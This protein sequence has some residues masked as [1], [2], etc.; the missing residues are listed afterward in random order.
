MQSWRWLGTGACALLLVVGCGDGGGDGPPDDGGADAGDVDVCSEAFEFAEG[1]PDGHADP[2]GVSAG[3]ARAGR[4]SASDLPPDPSGQGLVEEGDFVLANEH[5][6][7][8]IEDVGVSD[9]W[10]VWGGKPVGLGKMEGGAIVE[11]VN[12]YEMMLSIG[13]YTLDA[14][15]VTVLDDGSDGGPARVRAVGTLRI[16]ESLGDLIGLAAP[17]SNALFEGMQVALDYELAP[18]ARAME[19]TYQIVND[20]DVDLDTYS[21][22]LFF[23]ESRLPLY[24]PGPG[25]AYA[26]G[27]TPLLAY[28]A[29]GQSG[30]AW[31]VPADAPDPGET[32][33]MIRQSGATV[34]RFPQFTMEA[35]RVHAQPIGRLHVGGPGLDG[36]LQ[37]VAAD[38]D[39]SQREITGTIRNDD[40]TPAEGVS[41]HVTYEE[42]GE[43]QYLTK[44]TT[45]AD[46]TYAVH[47]PSDLEVEIATWRRGDVP[48]GPFT[49]AASDTGPVDIDLDPVGEIR[50]AAEDEPSLNP[51]PVRVQ[52]IPEGPEAEYAAAPEEYGEPELPPGRMHVA[53]PVDGEAVLRVPPG[54]HRVVVSRGFEYTLFDE[55]I[56][57]GAGESEPVPVTLER[58]V[59]TTGYMCA[60]FHIHTADSPDAGDPKDF[61]IRTAIG[62]G[63]E[64]P[65]LSDHRWVGDFEETIAQMDPAVADWAYGVS[66]LELTT[67]VWG[68]MGVVPL[69]TQPD[70][71]NNGYIDFVG[72]DPPDVFAEVRSR[73]SGTAAGIEPAIIIN[74]GRAFGGLPAGEYFTAVE[75]SPTTGTIGR[76]EWWDESFRLIEVFNDAA[77]DEMMDTGMPTSTLRDWFSMLSHFVDRPFFAVGSSDSHDVLKKSSPVGYPRTCLN[78][79]MTDD[80]ADLRDMDGS[81]MIRDIAWGGDMNVYGGIFVTAS[82]EGGTVPMGG[83]VEGSSTTVNVRVEAPCW[84]AVDRL[85]WWVNGEPPSVMAGTMEDLSTEWE[86]QCPSPDGVFSITRDVDIDVSDTTGRSWVVFHAAGDTTMDPMHRGR[87]PF[88]V[89]NPIFFMP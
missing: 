5:V 34:F 14:E 84:I 85:E 17:F 11:P 69:A 10:D 79:D 4:L 8:A 1:E 21:L 3:E 60:D 27:R 57:V 71:P 65:V 53:F 2:L 16:I 45:G 61:K 38:R 67:F 12:F 88:G 42:E 59:D 26:E 25:Y 44:A 58:V 37:A 40:G 32:S 78:F 52:V 35:C 51:L 41:V 89:T 66:S 19:V 24:A 54:D 77:F 48:A 74:H 6:A 82:A 15:S 72:M 73:D 55:V 62:D 83:T 28:A 13:Q 7:V 63:V 39:E 75:Y 47:V 80:P 23:Q 86:D 50:V 76:P 49:V 64:I 20:E 43:T 30:Y 81:A 29:P 9:L 70:L 87:L 56:S 33:F 36:V 22:H 31:E 18:G 46:G 68:H